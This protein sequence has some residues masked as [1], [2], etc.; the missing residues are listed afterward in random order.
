MRIVDVIVQG[1]LP[2]ATDKNS[3]PTAMRRHIYFRL[4]NRRRKTN[5]T[6]RQPFPPSTQRITLRAKM[7]RASTAPRIRNS[8]LRQKVVPI[9]GRNVAIWDRRRPVMVLHSERECGRTYI[10]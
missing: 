7:L 8:A 5:A 2:I 9:A 3:N 4:L 1:R 10:G 6:S